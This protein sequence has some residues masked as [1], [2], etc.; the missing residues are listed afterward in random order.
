M[1][2]LQAWAKDGS[3]WRSMKVKHTNQ[4]INEN[5]KDVEIIA[6]RF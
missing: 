3:G 4:S 1:M 6:G 5:K 2:P